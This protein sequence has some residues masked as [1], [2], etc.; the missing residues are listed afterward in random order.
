[1]SQPGPQKTAIK[2]GQVAYN[3]VDIHSR[4]DLPSPASDYGIGHAPPPIKGSA[5]SDKVRARDSLR[6][7]IT[8]LSEQSPFSTHGSPFTFGPIEVPEDG[9][10][11][12]PY[13]GELK[14]I[15]RDTADISSELDEKLRPV[16]KTAQ[17][18]VGRTARIPHTANVIGEV[19]NPGPVPLEKSSITSLDLLAVSGGPIEA[20][21]LYKYTLRRNGQDYVFDYQGF[22]TNPF[23]VE[24]GD[25]LTVNSDT[26][27][28]FHV[29]GAIN[30][31]MTVPFPVP[32]PTLADAIGA[33]S[34]FDERRSDPSGVFVFRKGNPDTVYTLNL[35]DPASVLLT[36]RFAIKGEDIVYVT[37][38]PL[39]RWSR[40][41]SQLL[42]VSQF[43][44]AAYNLDR[45]RQ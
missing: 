19:R 30:K 9:R 11:N 10:V 7:V 23:P 27:H 6:F 24:E 31:P 1:M 12:I 26:S 18:S 13:V 42:P 39:T 44:Q 25:L 22:R 32:F 37:E 40:L 16:S 8:D 21:H 17:G 38:A 43:S 3:L 5:Y 15:G 45:I 28:R 14:V 20:D 29:M 36:Q 34:G 41:I 4:A 35:K 33:A 2:E